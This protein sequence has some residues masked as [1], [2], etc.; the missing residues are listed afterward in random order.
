LIFDNDTADFVLIAGRVRIQADSSSGLA[1]IE[2]NRT[3]PSQCPHQTDVNALGANY[4][5]DEGKQE[6]A[7][8]VGE[9][10]AARAALR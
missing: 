6:L 2:P 1:K 5:H 4:H 10:A 9:G 7:S 8:K 3:F